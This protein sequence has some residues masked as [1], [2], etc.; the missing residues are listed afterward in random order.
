MIKYCIKRCLRSLGSLC[1]IIAIVFCLLRLMPI[2]GYF[3]SYDKM[4]EQQI[5]NALEKM[6]LIDPLPEQ[7]FRFYHQLLKGD[8]GDSIKYRVNYPIVKII[9]QK[10]PISI[11]FGLSAMAISLPLGLGLGI[12]MARK[13]G[14][15]WDRIGTGYIIFIQA[16][17]SAIYYLF[18]QLY[19]SRT[20]HLNVL[21]DPNKPISMLLPVISLAM[22]S[23]A[24]Y[25]MWL[26]RYMVDETNKD[27]IK[28][29]KAKGVPNSAIW[30]KHV[31]RNSIVPMVQLIP[32]SLLLTIAGSIYVESLYSIPGMGGLLV[33]VI[34]RQD[35]TMVQA[36]V[37]IFATLSILGLL[38][39]DVLMAIIDPRIK[40]G[41][42]GEAR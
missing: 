6:G 39:G 22:P 31:F 17:P 27:Y 13:K 41:K 30:F 18:I 15:W 25:A 21:Y 42:K 9:Q 26:R 33:E 2:E 11:K 8:L 29:A 7:L 1:I 14:G 40:L 19:G 35:N 12:L 24:S 28:L 38:L 32:S 37:I 23:I 36:L 20:F 5:E 16:V 4:S 34:K 10:A 3:S